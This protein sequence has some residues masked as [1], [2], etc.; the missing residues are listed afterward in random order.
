MDY[1]YFKYIYDLWNKNETLL[2]SNW[3][4]VYVRN[5]LSQWRIIAERELDEVRVCQLKSHALKSRHLQSFSSLSLQTKWEKLPS[6]KYLPS[7]ICKL[8][9]F[10]NSVISYRTYHFI[11]STFIKCVKLQLSTEILYALQSFSILYFTQGNGRLSIMR[12][13]FGHVGKWYSVRSVNQSLFHY[14]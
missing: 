4:I 7:T 13:K 1:I 8:Y 12:A 2:C 9:T 10:S 3:Y 6:Q 5:G 14:K 11:S